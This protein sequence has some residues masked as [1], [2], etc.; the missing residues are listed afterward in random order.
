MNEGVDYSNGEF[1]S[2]HTEDINYVVHTSA[3]SF[4]DDDNDNEE[5]KTLSSSRSQ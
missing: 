1:R 4:L 3:G 2:I 5:M